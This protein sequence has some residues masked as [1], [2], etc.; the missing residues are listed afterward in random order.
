MPKF[1]AHII[2][3]EM[4]LEREPELIPDVHVNS[5]RLG[6]IGP[7]TTLFMFDPFLGKPEVMTAFYKILEVFESIHKVKAELE[8]FSAA[9]NDPLTDLEDYLSGGLSKHLGYSF[10][11]CIEV[12]LQTAKFGAA[13]TLGS[14]RMKNPVYDQLMKTPDILGAITNPD[15]LRE[16]WH[17]EAP[18]NFGFPFRYFGHPY[19]DDPGWVSPK[20]VGDYSE[21]WWMDMLHYRKTGKYASA[22]R[23]LAQGPVQKSF[24]AGYTTHYA[25]DISGHPFI[26][27]LV[28]GPFRGHA[29]RHQ[30]LETI[31]DSWLWQKTGRG[32]ILGS[33]IDQ[34]IDLG[35]DD[36]RHVAKLLIK[37][38]KEVYKEPRLPK[39]LQPDGYPTEEQFLGGYAL[40]RRYLRLATSATIPKPPIPA[41]TPDEIRQQIEDLIKRN[42]PGRPPNLGGSAWDYMKALFSWCSKGLVWF[43]MLL[44]LPAAALMRIAM[45]APNWLIYLVN[46]ALYFII[47]AIRTMICLSGWGYCSSEDFSNFG[48]MNAMIRSKTYDTN[49]YPS[50][51]LDRNRGAYYWLNTPATNKV[52]RPDGFPLLPNAH[53]LWPDWMISPNNQ[54]DESVFYGLVHAT[55][56][57][58]TRSIQLENSRSC[59]FGNAV[60]FSISLLRDTIPYHDFDLDGDRGYGFKGWEGKSPDQLY[61]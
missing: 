9:V 55:D 37:A 14:I 8:K 46:Q 61:V 18:D 21:W 56:P 57:A 24:A 43:V 50:N 58:Q 35:E 38:M 19:T 54:M 20:P 5:L 15:A 23:S 13:T 47:S 25:G 51:A 11:A 12:L 27:S 48:F 1:G 30:V 22:L 31:A 29:Y 42:N 33:Q 10:N 45:I 4:V 17:I 49:N 28:G 36:Q 3:A 60:D 2:F 34:L 32:D 6:A 44:T 7:D 53:S 16:Y 52:E 39:L 26:N 40:M 59:G 41:T